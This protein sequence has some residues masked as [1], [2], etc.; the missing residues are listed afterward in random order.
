MAHALV[1][2]DRGQYAV[3]AV[4]LP[5]LQEGECRVAIRYSGVSPG[6][7]K[8]GLLGTVKFFEGFPTIM[9]YQSV[10]EI[11]ES[12]HR[13]FRE[14]ER[15]FVRGARFL[16]PLVNAWGGH[17]SEVVT[18]RLMR[19]APRVSHET[20]A[21]GVLWAVGWRGAETAGV[22]RGERVLV[23]GLGLVGQMTAALCRLRG[24][25]VTGIDT[26]AL[27]REIAVG[28]AVDRV[29]DGTDA[30]LEARLQALGPADVVFDT[31]GRPEVANLG[32][33][34]LRKRGRFIPQGWFVPTLPI[35]FADAHRREIRCFFPCGFDGDDL[36]AIFALAAE[37]QIDTEPLITHRVPGREA[38]RAYDLMLGPSDAYLGIM[39][40]W[41]AGR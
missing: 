18:N 35:A 1:S 5:E 22:E 7:E 41:S 16:P 17:C 21:F 39:I 32:I 30:E 8:H 33:R 40:D 6:T 23:F 20:A 13:D 3:Q 14:G 36:A 24:A 25:D 29:F 12:R 19:L 37:G 34:C 10:G 28:K 11:R 26:V 2:I 4:A 15:V 27:R 38:T 31:T 9:G